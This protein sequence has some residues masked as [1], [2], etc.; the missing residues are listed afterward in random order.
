M[1][2]RYTESARHHTECVLIDRALRWSQVLHA[3]PSGQLLTFGLLR[4]SIRDD[5]IERNL[6][7][8]FRPR[9]PEDYPS[10]EHLRQVMLRARERLVTIL[11]RR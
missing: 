6:K 1:N 9:Q 4:K 11:P 7:P 10:V 2:G 5:A 8:F 3:G